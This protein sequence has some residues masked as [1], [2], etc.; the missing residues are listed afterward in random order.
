MLICA[1]LVGCCI[2]GYGQIIEENRYLARICIGA[3]VSSIYL[4]S[5]KIGPSIQGV[6]YQQVT[7]GNSSNNCSNN[8]IFHH[9]QPYANIS[10]SYGNSGEYEYVTIP[11][12]HN[13]SLPIYSSN[14]THV[15]SLYI[16]GPSVIK[17][18]YFI[19][20]AND[21]QELD[22]YYSC[23]SDF[24]RI[25]LDKNNN[26]Y[27]FYPFVS[28]EC[29][30]NGGNWVEVGSGANE[31][32]K[33]IH[34]SDV[35][36][37][38]GLDPYEPMFFRTK[39]E[40]SDGSYSISE[41]TNKKFHFFPE[42]QF[43]EGTDI[44]VEQSMCKSENIIVKIPY[45]GTQN[46]TVTFEGYGGGNI[47]LSTVETEL[48][49]ETSY[50]CIPRTLQAGNYNLTIENKLA[51]GTPCAYQTSFTVREIPDFRL[52]IPSYL[53]EVDLGGGN[54]VQIT[55]IDGTGDVSFNIA[56]SR[57]QNVTVHAGG[58][59]FFRTL[60][61]TSVTGGITYYSDSIT[62]SL[63]QGN[64]NVFVT[65]VSCTSNEM[66]AT[67]NQP[68]AISFTAT[69][70]PPSCNSNSVG[71][72]PDTTK[73]T[74][75]KIVITSVSGGL[76][77]Y[78][79]YID[80][81]EFNDSFVGLSQGTYTIKVSDEHG[82]STVKN[83]TVPSP[84]I[85][86][87]NTHNA[88]TPSSSCAYDGKITVSASGGTGSFQY[89]RTQ[90]DI[91]SSSNIV[92]GYSGG[93]NT[94]YVEDDCGC[95]VE[96]KFH[97]SAPDSLKVLSRSYT[98]PSCYGENNGSYIIEFENVTGEL[99]TNYIHSLAE[100]NKITISD[101]TAGTHYITITDT[102]GS[103]SCSLDVEITIPDKPAINI[104][105]TATNVG[106]KGSATGKIDVEVTGGNN[107]GYDIYL[108]EAPG[109]QL[110]VKQV[111]NVI[112][113][114][115]FE[116]LTG[117]MNGKSYY[118]H[119]TDS[120]GCPSEEKEIKVYEPA[121]A[122]SVSANIEVPI[123]C[124]GYTTAEIKLSAIGGWDEYQYSNDSLTWQTTPV[125][126]N[127]AAGTHAFYVKDT[128]NVIKS[129]DILITQP[130]PL[131]I[132]LDS[133]FHVLCHGE[134]TGFLRYKVSGGTSPYT[135]TS[136]T[137]TVTQ[138]TIDG[139][140]YFTI[141][142]LPAGKYTFTVT[143]VYECNKTTNEETIQ[144]PSKLQL[145]ILSTTNTTCE[146]DNGIIIAK[147]SGG[148]LPYSYKLENEGA[149]N[150]SQELTLN[151]TDDAKFEG[152]PSD[153]YRVT[154][155]DANGCWVQIGALEIKNYINPAVASVNTRKVNC[156]GENNGRV[157][158]TPGNLSTLPVQTYTLRNANSSYSETNT[159]GIF[160]NLFAD[161]YWV[162]VSD[163]NGCQSNNP[164]PV[165][166]IQPEILS[167]VIDT[168]LCAIGKDVNDGQVIFRVQGGNTGSKTV[169]MKQE[170]N[171]SVDSIFVVNG[172]EASFNASAGKYYLEVK[173][174]EG[175][176]TTSAVFEI[177]GPAEPLHFIVTEKSDALCKSQTGN[178]VVQGVGGWGDYRYKRASES[179][180]SS[181]NR[182]ENLYPGS[183]QI[184]V[185]DKFGAIYSENIIIYEPQDSLRAEITKIKLPTCEKNG[186]VSVLIQ[187]GTPPYKLYN[188]QDS[189]DC[190]QAQ[191]V[192][193]SGIGSGLLQLTLIDANGCR[194]ELETTL[195]DSAYLR[196]ERFRL[197]YPDDSSTSGAIE[198]TVSG[199]LAP[200]TYQWT[201]NLSEILPNNAPLL[202]NIS[203]GHY[204]L[205]V[206]DASGCSVQ[207][208]VYLKDPN[209]IPF[210]ILEIGHETSFEATN[211]YALLY[212][213]ASLTDFTLISPQLSS[214][215]YAKTD[216]N[217]RFKVINDTIHLSSLENGKWFVLGTTNSGQQYIAEF[218]INP[219][220]DFEFSRISVTPVAA[221]GD[222]TGSIKLE[223]AGGGGGNHFAWFNS[224]NEPL[225]STDDEYS[226]TL[227]N[228]LAGQYTVI[229]TDRYGNQ[230]TETVSVLEPTE[231][232]TINLVDKKD[233]DCHTYENAY[234]IVS[235]SGGWGDYQ[236]RHDSDI[237]FNNGSSFSGLSTRENYFFVVDKMGAMDSIAVQITEPEFLRAH[238]ISVD[239]V[240]CK[241]NA[242]GSILF[243]IT[244]GTPPY[245][246][247]EI[248]QTYWLDGNHAINRREGWYTYIFTDAN[249]CEG[250]DT[251][252]VYVP[253]PD[254]LVFKD[255][256]VTHTTCNL[257]NGQIQVILQ[258]GTQPYSYNWYDFN[259]VIIGNE[260]TIKDLKQNG[261]YR[262]L[263]TDA[264]GCT[265]E[266]EQLINPSTLPRILQVET[267]EVLC[268]SDTTGT[269]RVT[270]L[271]PAAPYA[272]YTLTWSN[273]DT[274]DFSARFEKG[275][276]YV[277]IE[278]ENGCSTTY[279]F[280]I[281]EPDSLRLNF[282]DVREP[283][284]YGYG[285][286][287][288]GTETFGGRGKYSYL[289]STRATTPYIE[290]LSKGN[291]WVEVTDENGCSYRKEITLNEPEYQ[292][293]DLG[294][295][296]NIC[297]GNTI[298]IDGQDFVSHRWFTSAGTVSTQRYLSVNKED[299]YFLEA[300]NEQ[301]CSVWGNIS[302]FI[303]NQA[304]IADLLLPSQV[305]V[306]DTLVAFEL[307]NMELDSLKWD[308]DPTVFQRI[309]TNNE[310]DLPYAAEFICLQ[311]GIFEIGLYAYAE[312]CYSLIYKELEVNAER[313]INSDEWGYQEP[314]IQSVSQYPNPTDGRFKIDVELREAK[315][316]NLTLFEIATGIFMDRKT[317]SGDKNY[318]I[319]YDIAGL[320]TG[321][322]TLIVMV[323]NE[324]KQIKIIVK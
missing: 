58:K 227:N 126:S 152:L 256:Q 303:G 188:E 313:E 276:H 304:L 120:E 92:G 36:G 174:N 182:F 108:Y 67:L 156:F 138:S 42:F 32:Y 44:I 16:D 65:N 73:T 68:N 267:T 140:Q 160:E 263:V 240:K 14:Y 45:E 302:V 148:V 311:E 72:V 280:E 77:S 306:G 299:N 237:Y 247:R 214:Y 83:I 125:F 187:G 137:G 200:Y 43:P 195:S 56:G 145:S 37:L 102:F 244:G 271:L 196:L 249:D 231:K 297:P 315:E 114:Y 175:C 28:F 30:N 180:F 219:Y 151:N 281:T 282:V 31:D 293:L 207:E 94:V 223:I 309:E 220:L 52:S 305:A 118:I 257:D 147:A 206:T 76:G 179:H 97:L 176:T 321:V 75:G 139:N 50:Y 254:L 115:R 190:N 150:Y 84:P 177:E 234:V 17:D 79:Y 233:Q 251:L 57:T 226:S 269:A 159:I 64:Y 101:L 232:L 322:Y 317:V 109:Q 154:I 228:I 273:G 291:Y 238:I 131:S 243:G 275:T 46:Y 142:N 93:E 12:V 88:V 8:M 268:Y 146:L 242:D 1:F 185:I 113:N 5:L 319:D 54:K 229:V 236:F 63:H 259:N 134:A 6:D 218:T 197:T 128:M 230:I 201:R 166:I 80:S 222:A 4:N 144:E 253:E 163:A 117:D 41:Y 158:V 184:Q 173:D 168:V 320:G 314:L 301:G 111:S 85:I 104:E 11:F 192:E 49:D 121:N 10:V 53:D 198:A 210:E 260:P 105:A 22:R 258:G 70:T 135:L 55:K 250:Q 61:K 262:L 181:L 277:T 48:I 35:S 110:L 82:N 91:S 323:E 307:S 278:D 119:V 224:L 270:D 194:F 216:V 215:H 27:G 213:D 59:T 20:T 161:Q 153:F 225:F 295:D 285:N 324:R 103:I 178:I 189:I 298:V 157:E 241:G 284:C 169:W 29:R 209:D 248:G 246:F 296:R 288:I 130:Q 289:W 62:I 47:D 34:F 33:N 155:T 13:L 203:S 141:S 202:N 170:D 239:S 143:D 183:Y 99:S 7:L 129:T 3:G 193:W 107:D 165:T 18:I 252:N 81:T 186:S 164:Y 26:N 211:G 292:T 116:N 95:I 51:E 24:I 40:L 23:P 9:F 162:V 310:Y 266:Y 127:Y 221:K 265:V 2:K 204:A 112:S 286:G 123:L 279:Y 308:Y 96:K 90:G 60:T 132:E 78:K 149:H 312:G 316:V 15:L 100:G 74:D 25:Y 255:I 171:N 86:T 191:E 172:F 318:Q 264:N 39:R 283:Q 274:G 272:P 122:L 212:A 261:A 98:A 205:T 290:H 300:T 217:N 208:T 38:N 245:R 124:Y 19:D 66:P 21:F 71:L 167:I 136:T 235:A 294:E 69:P 106:D 287:Y 89:G 199:G 87:V 133:I